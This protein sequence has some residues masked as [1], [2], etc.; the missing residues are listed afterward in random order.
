MVP[1][2]AQAC[3]RPV[4]AYAEG[5]A[6]ESVVEGETGVLVSEQSVGAFAD[7]I[8][9]ASNRAFDTSAIRRHAEGFS[10][11]RFKQEFMTTLS[12]DGCPQ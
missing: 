6:L 3:G 9:T 4:I 12:L 8:A 10:I 7:A 2:E 11:A 1:V 5:G